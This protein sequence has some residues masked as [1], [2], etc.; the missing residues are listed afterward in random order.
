MTV[1]YWVMG[2]LIVG[3]LV[4]SALCMLLYAFTGHDVLA[5]RASTLWA[6]TRTFALLGVNVLI[7][8]HVAAGLWSIWFP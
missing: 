7:W 6:Y 1:F 3:T 4:P 5:R 2:V 8:G